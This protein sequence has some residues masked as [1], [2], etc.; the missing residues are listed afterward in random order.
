LINLGSLLKKANDTM[1]QT[2]VQP[3]MKV[4]Y[5]KSFSQELSFDVS[6][7]KIHEA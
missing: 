4:V 5:L 3:Q 6:F 7:F 2:S 1:I